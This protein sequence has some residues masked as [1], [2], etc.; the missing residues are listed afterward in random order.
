MVPRP[1]YVRDFEQRKMTYEREEGVS[2][3]WLN[4]LETEH[5]ATWACCAA[6]DIIIA[7]VRMTPPDSALALFGRSFSEHYG[8][9]AH[10]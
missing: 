7:V 4:L 8:P 9:R 10:S 3:S 6:V 2:V 5:V 1:A